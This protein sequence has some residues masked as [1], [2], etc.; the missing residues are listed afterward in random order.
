MTTKADFTA[1]EWELVSGLPSLVLA[2]A[3]WADGKMVPAVREIVAGGQVLQQAAASAPEG[4]LVRDLFAGATDSKEAKETMGED[5]PSSPQDAVEKLTAKVGE[6]FALLEAK[7]TPE[8]VASVRT[9]LEATAKAVVE[10]LGSGFWGSG[11]DKVSEG[12][13]AYLERLATVLGDAPSA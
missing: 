13:K 5:K 6:A 9:T 11:A 2:G 8:E 4:S 12:E 3:A 10:R 7:A 1:E